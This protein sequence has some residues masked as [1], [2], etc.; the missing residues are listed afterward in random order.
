[1]LKFKSYTTTRITTNLFHMRKIFCFV[2]LLLTFVGCQGQKSNL[3]L[4]L[5][6]GETYIQ[7]VISRV[8]IDQKINGQEMKMGMLVTGKVAFKVVDVVGEEYKM[9][10]KYENL[11]LEMQRPGGSI[12]QKKRK[13]QTFSPPFLL[14]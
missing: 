13:E 12:A 11:S 1:M 6:K 10:A 8:D 2:L 5:K 4:N 14:K 9:D 3:G 7:N